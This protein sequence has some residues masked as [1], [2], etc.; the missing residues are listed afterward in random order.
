MLILS[1]L[2]FSPRNGRPGPA[3]HQSVGH[4]V[5]SGQAQHLN[6][7]HRKPADHAA[8]ADPPQPAAAGSTPSAA[9][10]QSAAAAAPA[11]ARAHSAPRSPCTAQH[12]ELRN[13]WFFFKKLHQENRINKKTTQLASVAAALQLRR[14]CLTPPAVSMFKSY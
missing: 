5:S 13:N 3:L 12:G 4:P 7:H 14:R 8:A 9:R 1:S 10:P 6:S 11:A 2:F